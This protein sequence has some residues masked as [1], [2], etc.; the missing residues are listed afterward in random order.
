[1]RPLEEVEVRVLE[2]Q[3]RIELPEPYRAFLREVG[4]SGAGPYYG[5]LPPARWADALYGDVE[6]LDFAARPCMWTPEGSRDF[7]ALAKDLDEPFQGAIAIA[8]QGCAYYAMLVVTGSARGRVMY[9]SLD[10]GAPFFPAETFLDWYERWLDE[11][12]AGFTHFWYGTNMPGT[13]ATFAAAAR[14]VNPAR[15]LDALRAMAQLPA[16]SPDTRAIIALRVRDDDAAVRAQAMNL[17]K[18]RKL[19]PSL[20]VH[21]RRA[22]ADTDA[23]VRQLALQ[24]LVEAKLDWHAAAVR[25]FV[26]PEPTV[27][28][29]AIREL[30]RAK[31][32]TEDDLLPLIANTKTRQAAHYAARTVPSQRIFDATVEQLRASGDDKYSSLLHTLLAQV[33]LDAVDAPRRATVL[34]MLATRLATTTDDEPDTIAIYGLGAI[35]KRPDELGARAVRVLVDLLAH[36]APFFRFEA[37]AV[38]GDV[39]GPNVLPALRAILDDPAM[40]RAKTRS[41]SWSVG[42][43]ARRATAKIEA[44]VAER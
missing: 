2:Q 40:P 11:L 42:E 34:D 5:L 36:R 41:T 10:G 32:L 25:A 15:R 1:M 9:V 30:E 20:E 28:S 19:A 3:H 4:A 21:V 22:L 29:N 14:D 37:A 13:E 44:V 33:R 16:L 23:S 27:A 18:H 7:D 24:A 17:V 12:L 8:D 35:A 39:A 31:A 38:L 26:D 6:M 43:S